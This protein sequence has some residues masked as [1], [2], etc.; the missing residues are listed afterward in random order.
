MQLVEGTERE[1][2][3]AAVIATKL[4]TRDGS[5][6]WIRTSRTRPRFA[7]DRDKFG[8]TRRSALSDSILQAHR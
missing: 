5:Y 7:R 4:N 2:F 1:R 3:L 8:G 6:F